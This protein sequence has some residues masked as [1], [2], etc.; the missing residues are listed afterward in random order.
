MQFQTRT[1]AGL[2]A[3]LSPLLQF[4]TQSGFESATQRGRIHRGS[5]HTQRTCVEHAHVRCV[6]IQLLT[7]ASAQRRTTPVAEAYV[8]ATVHAHAHGTQDAGRGT[9]DMGNDYA[10]M[11]SA[12]AKWKVY[13]PVITYT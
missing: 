6:D 1:A 4:S 8:T 10:M 13:L 7:S 5:R 9:R 11:M 2:R 3:A 12:C